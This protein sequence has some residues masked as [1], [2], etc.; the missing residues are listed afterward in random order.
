MD[1]TSTELER[2][3]SVIARR[4]GMVFTEAR[5]PFLRNRA[6]EL[7]TR[8]GFGDPAGWTA[9]L[10][11]ATADPG[12]AYAELEEALQIHETSF[13]RYETHHRVL[14]ETVIPEIIREIAPSGR[15][16]IRIWDVA[17]STGEEPYSIAMTA[18]E[19][20]R[21]SP[22]YSVEIIASDASREALAV[23]T[24]G[25]YSTASVGSIPP[26]Y[27]A[28]YFSRS[29]DGYEV[30][31]VLR[32]LVRFYHQDVRRSLYIGKFDV[33]FC[34]NL[35]LYFTHEVKREI[36]SRLVESVRDGGYLF[37]GHAEGIAPPASLFHSRHLPTGFVYRRR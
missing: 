5:W 8:N 24:R 31:P 27:L 3:S 35:L 16:R 6:R 12:G 2:L 30:A 14:R 10:E 29:A 19:S 36:L 18:H 15:R 4:S 28:R 20:L 9:M 11:A 33:M 32:E 34:C 23:A 1:L 25:T 22:A 7:M 26:V 13:F 21:R 17:C 37:L